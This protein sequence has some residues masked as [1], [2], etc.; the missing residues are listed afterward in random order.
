[1]KVRKREGGL[2]MD[3]RANGEGSYIHIV[4]TKCEK[5]NH[6]ELVSPEEILPG[7]HYFVGLK[8]AQMEIKP[9]KSLAL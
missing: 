7:I 4:P 2:I 6:F 5:C 9:K 1:M 8:E 3:R